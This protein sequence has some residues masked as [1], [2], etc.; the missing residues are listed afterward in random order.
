MGMVRW[1]A[2][3]CLRALDRWIA[4]S[5]SF[6]A[7]HLLLRSARKRLAGAHAARCA[8]NAAMFERE[9]Q[10]GYVANHMLG[11]VAQAGRCSLAHNAPCLRASASL[12]T[13]AIARIPEDHRHDPLPAGSRRRAAPISCSSR[14]TTSAGKLSKTSSRVRMTG[15]PRY[16]R[17][18]GFPRTKIHRRRRGRWRAFR[19]LRTPQHGTDPFLVLRLSWTT[20]TSIRTNVDIRRGLSGAMTR[21]GDLPARCLIGGAPGTSSSAAKFKASSSAALVSWSSAPVFSSICLKTSVP[22]GHGS[23]TFSRILASM[24][25]GDWKSTGKRP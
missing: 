16:G 24:T 8:V 22:R 2:R 18:D 10:R 12:R 11:H 1:P 15:S 13:I 17:P 4:S 21:M 23:S 3:L 20:T 19:A 25:D 5:R 6:R 14:T 7:S 9:N